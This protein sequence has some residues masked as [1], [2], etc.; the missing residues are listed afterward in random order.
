MLEEIVEKLDSITFGQTQQACRFRSLARSK[1][2][3]KLAV[4]NPTPLLPYPDYSSPQAVLN[5]IDEIC[6]IGRLQKELPQAKSLYLSHFA[7]GMNYLSGQLYSKPELQPDYVLF[8]TEV[9]FKKFSL[10]YMPAVDH[11]DADAYP[12]VSLIPQD[13][14]SYGAVFYRGPLVEDF[15]D[16]EGLFNQWDKN[17][18]S[19]LSDVDY[20][21]LK[22]MFASPRI[23]SA[24]RFEKSAREH[25]GIQNMYKNM[26]ERAYFEPHNDTMAKF[27]FWCA[28]ILIRKS[29]S[30]N[31][32]K[33]DLPLLTSKHLHDTKTLVC[34][35]VKDFYEDKGNIYSCSLINPQSHPV[36]L[37]NVLQQ[38]NRA[39]DQQTISEGD[40]RSIGQAL[41]QRQITPKKF[42]L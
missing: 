18:R 24:R 15:D 33:Q 32:L 4:I 34:R 41:L 14:Y 26:Q 42:S 29:A 6:R 39:N 11:F 17:K 28:D 10:G 8:S 2:Q 16:E 13:Q 37:F 38:V 9:D 7:A 31:A 25:K 20:S 21:Q 30:E 19:G 36:D 12:F 22:D 35:T 5:N 3:L 27:N 23:N 1:Y 40:A